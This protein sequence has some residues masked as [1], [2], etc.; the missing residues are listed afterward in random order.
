MN[1]CPRRQPTAIVCTNTT[2]PPSARKRSRRRRKAT[3]NRAHSRELPPPHHILRPAGSTAERTGGAC[4]ACRRPIRCGP[5]HRQAS[6]QRQS[7]ANLIIDAHS[8]TFSTYRSCA[9]PLSAVSPLITRPDRGPPIHIR[10]HNSALHNGPPFCVHA[11]SVQ[12]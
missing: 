3:R 1:C 2:S 9:L 10:T 7:G 12:G 5:P 4:I 8:R 11:A 6:S